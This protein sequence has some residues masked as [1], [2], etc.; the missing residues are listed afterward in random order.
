MQGEECME[1]DELLA[2]INNFRN[3]QIEEDKKDE[4]LTQISD[5]V[6]SVFDTL[7]TVSTARDELTLSN[8]QLRAANMKLFMKIGEE[9][10]ETTEEKVE[11][12]RTKKR[13]FDDLFNEKGEFK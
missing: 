11:E 2:L 5:G 3:G 1:R 6:S 8:E 7:A 4:L 9:K 12:E 13:S 10:K